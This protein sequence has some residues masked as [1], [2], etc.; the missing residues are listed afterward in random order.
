MN[1]REV[2]EYLEQAGS[3]GSVFGINN[4]RNLCEELGNPQESLQ[5]VHIAG[6]NGKGSTL[7]FVST[8]LK[9]AGYKVGRYISP[10]IKDYRE[11]IQINGRMISKASLRNCTE[12]IKDA[13]ERMEKKGKERPTL[14]EIETAMAFLYFKEKQ[15]DIVILE[16]GLG[17][18]LDATNIIENTLVAGIAS[19]SRDHMAILGNSLEKIAEQKA[20]IIKAGCTVVSMV[21]EQNVMNVITQKAGEY[22]CPLVV[23]DAA[24]ASGIRHGIEKQKFSYK[25]WKNLEISL[26][27]Q[28]QIKNAVLAIEI[29]QALSEKGFAWKEEQLR[30]GLKETEWLGRFTVIDKKPYFIIDGAHNEDG[31]RE[32]A[33]SVKFYFTNK[34]IIYI[35]GILK[36]KE[37]EKVVK[38][39]CPLADAI[40]TVTS[41]NNPRALSAYELASV[42]KEYHDNV[43]AV[44]SIEEA[45][46]MSSLMAD[47]DSVI[48]AFGSLS[49]LGKLIEVVESRK[50]KRR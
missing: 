19:I 49:Y 15:C 48:L 13:I 47:K 37:Y 22:Q 12:Q 18:L 9:V 21:Q 6:T 7:A 35:M 20:G 41:P 29:L 38:E 40:I 4:I 46:E 11:R 28:Y 27:G 39:T 31:A 36:D 3:A 14:F 8:V 23:A 34:R 42:V 43:T 44:D 32:L 24:L 30:K 26:V 25:E 1:D 50:G 2:M 17:G 5:F 16:A 33:K 10:T 45:V